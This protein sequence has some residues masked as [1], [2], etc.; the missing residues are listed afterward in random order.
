ML[1][2]SPKP[3]SS[4]GSKAKARKNLFEHAP[5]G[6]HEELICCRRDKNCVQELTA[7]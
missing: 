1:S 7:S 5:Y 3:G 6:S 2:G 4:G